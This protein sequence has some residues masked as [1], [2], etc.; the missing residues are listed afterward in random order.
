MHVS[1]IYLAYVKRFF[2]DKPDTA[3]QVFAGVLL[4]SWGSRKTCVK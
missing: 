3:I 1:N 2:L 4:Q